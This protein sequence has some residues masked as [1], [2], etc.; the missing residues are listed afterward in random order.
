MKAGFPGMHEI[1]L[2]KVFSEWV[3]FGSKKGLRGIGIAA[4]VT[5]WHNRGCQP[6]ASADMDRKIPVWI[7][8]HH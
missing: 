8:T 3:D 4:D 6:P 7:N 2:P 1:P 5:P